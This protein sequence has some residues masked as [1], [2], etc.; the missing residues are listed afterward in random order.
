MM[1]GFEVELL[2]KVVLLML[3]IVVG[4]VFEVVKYL[5]VDKFNVCQVDVGIGVML[6]IVCGVLNV[7][8]GIKVLVVLVG[9]ELLLVEEGGKLFV[10]KLLKLCGVESQ[11]MLCLVCELKLFEDYS[12]LL[13]LLEDMLVGQDI[14]EIFNFD[15]MIFEIK[16]MLN[17]VDC[18]LVFGIVCEMVVIIGVLLM[19]VDI[20]LVNVEFDEMLFVCIVVFDLC[21]C[22]LGCVICGVN[23]Y[24]KMLQWMV[25][26]FECLGQCSVFVFVDILNYVM[27]E[28]GCLLYVFDFDKIYG[29]IEVCWGKCGEL[30]KLFN[31]NMVEF[32]EMVGVIVDDCQVESLVGIMGGDSMVVMFDMINIYLEVVFWWLDSIC[33]CVCKYNFLI[34]VVYCFECGVDYVMIVEYVECIMQLIFEIC[35]GKVGLVDDQVVNLLQCVLVKMCVLCV[36]C[37]IGVKIDV[38]EIV[39]IF[40]CFGLLFECEDDVFFVMLLL[41]CFDIEIEEDLIE[42]VVC[43]YGFEKILVWL[44]VVMSEMCV[45]YEIWWLIYDICYV[46]VVCD[47]VEI[48]NFSF[49]DVEWEYDFVG[50]DNLICLL[51]LIVSQFLVMCM[52]LFGSL[53]VVLCY[54]LNCCVD[55][56]CVFELGCVFVVDLLVKVGELV[57]EGYVQFKCV[58]VLVYGLVFDEQWGV[59]ICVVDFFDVKG[60]FEVLFV[61]VV[62]CFVKVEYLVFYLGCGVCIEIDGCVVGWIGE[63]YLCLMQ[64]YELLYLLVM[65]EIDVDVLIVCVLFVLIDVLKFL[66]V[67]CDIVVVVDQV[68]EVQVFFDEMKKVFVE[69]VC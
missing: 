13:I 69:E 22:F 33:G 20:C 43:I 35:G 15:D 29:G 32:D 12:G 27:F 66:L 48:V 59:M 55:C 52:M 4:C 14:C 28:F 6:N 10:I 16:L 26:C 63:L 5:D 53:I 44:L 51:N 18:L 8:F 1:V 45:I 24:V 11:G 46:L 21:G 64:K 2:S 37:I 40:M 38:D 30:L 3:K 54:N 36:N 31:G 49:V 50:N 41:Y 65:F 42:E 58:G 17:K 67:C 23:V 25:E 62:V 9:V 61:L 19:L 34:D 47:Y 60:D 56:V 7:V 68:V 39:D 57:V